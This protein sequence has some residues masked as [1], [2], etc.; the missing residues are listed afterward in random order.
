MTLRRDTE[1]RRQAPALETP[2]TT[3]AGISGH[4]RYGALHLPGPIS[5]EHRQPNAAFYRHGWNSWS[6]TGWR[7]LTAEPLRIYDN[8]ARLLTADDIANDTPG[9]HS[10][11]AVGAI[12]LGDGQVVLLGGLGMNAPRVEA[13]SK[14]MHGYGDPDPDAAWYVGIGPE[15]DVFHEYAALLKERYGHAGGHCG[16][17]WSSWYSYFEDI[18]E[19]SIRQAIDDLEGWPFDVFQV[20]DGWERAVGDWRAN[21]DFPSGLEGLATD[22]RGHGFRPGLWVAPLITMPDAPF[23]LANPHLM[24]QDNSGHPLIAGYNWGKAYWALDTTQPEVQQYIADL[25][26]D[27]VRAGFTFFKLDFMYAGA[28]AGNRS[29]DTPRELAYRQAVQLIRDVVGPDT[30][31]LGSGVPMLPSLGLFDGV[32]VGPDTAPYWDNSERKRDQSGAS[33]VNALITSVNRAW[34]APLYELDPDV[35]FFR[36]RRNLL[37][38]ETRGVLIDLGRVLNFRATSDPVSWLDDEERQALRR[39]LTEHPS[40][41]QVGRY[42][43]H[44][45]S[46]EIDFEPYITP[47]GRISD[48]LLVK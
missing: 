14:V 26:S 31:L 47:N 36:S 7:R 37:D 17:L 18:D 30:Y 23:A 19:P 3:S 11:S 43:F 41:Q 38:D 8:P 16:N 44:V 12:E 13:D 25:F 39:F 4:T 29:T 10:G 5:I 35:A 28:L 22:I 2:S 48:R 34:M 1:P 24:I 9:R 6:P 15:A 45:G 32:R 42:R 27:L 46:R 33:A 40:V 20:D 21:S